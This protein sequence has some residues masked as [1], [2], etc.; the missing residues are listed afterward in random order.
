MTWWLLRRHYQSVWD[1]K[2]NLHVGYSNTGKEIHIIVVFANTGRE[3]PQTIEFVNKC[4]VAFGFHT[5]WV[6][7]KVFHGIR[8]GTSHTVVTYDNC[9][10]NGEPFEEVIKKYGIPNNKNKH[11][12]RE[13]KFRPITSYARSIG[14]KNN[15]YFSAV[16]YRA[17][18]PKRWRPEEKQKTRKEKRLVHHFAF[19]K[20]VN[21]QQVNTW[22]KLQSFDLGLEEWEGNCEA[23]IEKNDKKLVVTAYKCPSAFDWIQDMLDKYSHTLPPGK[24][25][26]T[27]VK[28]PQ[29]FYREYKTPDDYK[30]M[31][32]QYFGDLK[33][34]T[35][36]EVAINSLLNKK[37][38]ED[39]SVCEES[40]EPF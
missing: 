40:C 17:D 13:L 10:K 8:K 32:K 6:E 34:E 30:A 18:E 24:A 31:A 15:S 14:W 20:P 1:P 16:G 27:N 35:E 33:N 9:S 19:S 28:L 38:N 23:C 21:K 25:H 37:F 4:D 2:R 22:W 11:C 3:K 39:E 7:A 36:I 29:A 12:T 5:V 26:N